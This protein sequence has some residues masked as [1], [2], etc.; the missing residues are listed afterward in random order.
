[1]IF[2]P[3]IMSLFHF[4]LNFDN[5][6]EDYFPLVFSNLL[7]LLFFVFFQNSKRKASSVYRNRIAE[8]AILRRILA[9]LT[10]VR[11]AFNQN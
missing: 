10:A 6:F 1:M 11:E 8:L 3:R 7:V 4:K 9:K 5:L 2:S